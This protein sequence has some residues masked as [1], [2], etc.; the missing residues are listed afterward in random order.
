MKKQYLTLCTLA[1]LMF[2][3]LNQAQGQSRTHELGLRLSGLENFD[4][5]YK[6]SKDEQR[7]T[8]YRVLL[9]RGQFASHSN[10]DAVNIALGLAIGREHRKA[11]GR[12]LSFVHGWEPGFN[13]A[14][15]SGSDRTNIFIAP[16]LGYVLGFHLDISE[17]FYINIETIPSLSG[18]FR[19][20]DG[21][22]SDN[23]SV[24][25]G[26]NSNAVALTLAYRFHRE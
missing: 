12:N 19:I 6:R 20:N 24:D 17:S 26:F 21:E 7:F 4:F 1:F 8:R 22:I 11:I 3:V 2:S 25:F 16:F 18:N 9:G 10:G 15:S 13:I 23:Y 5:I 14:A